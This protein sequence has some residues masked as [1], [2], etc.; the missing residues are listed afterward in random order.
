M[1][2]AKLNVE[3]RQ[4]TNF[5]FGVTIK[6]NGLAVDL[7]GFTAKLQVKK[8]ASAP[9]VFIELRGGAPEEPI[10]ADPTAPGRLV[11]DFD[12]VVTR[13]PAGVYVY[14]ML[15]ALPGNRRV[16]PVEGTFTVGDSV[17]EL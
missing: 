10:Y 16:M 9:D 11:V 4:G 7:T 13:I 17:T 5:T 12:H 3:V 15:V 14:D 1:K 6:I 2:P 8:K